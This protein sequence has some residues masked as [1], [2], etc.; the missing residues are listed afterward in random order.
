MRLPLASTT[1]Q[2]PETQ[3]R[4]RADKVLAAAFPEHSRAAFQRALEAGLVK[5][6]GKVIAQAN[7]ALSG[8]LAS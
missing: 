5:A 1:Y 3:R 4:E 6:D 2:I 8:R 7:A